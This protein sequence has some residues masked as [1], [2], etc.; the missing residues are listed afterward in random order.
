[1]LKRTSR[2]LTSLAG[3]ALLAA[4]S[5]TPDVSKFKEQSNSFRLESARL[6]ADSATDQQRIFVFG[7]SNSK[8]GLLNDIEIIDPS[9]KNVQVLKDHIIPRRYFSA[10]YDG[11]KQIYLLGGVSRSGLKNRFESNVEVFN[12]ETRK[13]SEAAPLP[14][15]TRMNTAVFLDGKIYVLGGSHLDWQTRKPRST[16]IMAIY[17]TKT[18]VWSLGPPMPTVKATSAVTYNGS[19][20]VVGGFNEGE[21]LNVFE[22]FDP[23]TNEWTSL[24]PLPVKI[25]AHTTT[26]WRDY[27]IVFGDYNNLDAVWTYDFKAQQWHKS[28]LKITGVRHSS[29]VT[30]NDSVYLIGGNQSSPG[31][32]LDAIQVFDAKLLRKAVGK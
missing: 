22:Q 29:A 32:V 4:C 3:A 30:F 14:Y 24:P 19:V 31:P 6:G 9:T 8:S 16:A 15:P 27:L 28:D 17:D 11:D 26:V 13:I 23:T 7:G 25:S 2:L 12:T 5:S 21:Q 18:N 20:Y 1:M 10:V